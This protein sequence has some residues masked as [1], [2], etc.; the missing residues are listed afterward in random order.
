[1]ATISRQERFMQ[2]LRPVQPALERFALHLT[3]SRYEARELVADTIAAAYERF[4][5]VR[6]ERA[7]MSFLFTIAS[8]TWQAKRAHAARQV[9]TLPDDFDRLFDGGPSAEL[10]TDVRIL[11]DA[12]A[13]LP[14]DQRQAIILFEV[15]GFSLK[16]IATTQGCTSV[17]VKVRLHRAR[18]RLRAML[19]D[20]HSS[21]TV[22]PNFEE[23]PL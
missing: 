12:I 4:D 22:V 17:A 7:F 2:T 23:V 16:D 15:M 6:D 8:R 9:S 20:T 19:T 11:H 14:D 10:S 1:M 13:Q 3:H 18:K 21:P 5:T